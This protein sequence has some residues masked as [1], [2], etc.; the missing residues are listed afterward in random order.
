[1]LRTKRAPGTI[2]SDS[3]D[4]ETEE[5]PVVEEELEMAEAILERAVAQKTITAA[6]KAAEQLI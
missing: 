3:E 1:V 2:M 5:E 4:S 6:K